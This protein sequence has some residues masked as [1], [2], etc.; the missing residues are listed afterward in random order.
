M[1]EPIEDQ[2]QQ[3][4]HI[5]RSHGVK[6]EVLIISRFEAPQLFDEINLVHIQNTRGDLVPARIESYRAQHKK[7]RLSF[8]VKFEHV[9][10]R[11]KA[12]ELKG[13]PVFVSRDKLNFLLDGG[14]LQST[15][16]TAF[17]VINE[18][19]EPIGSVTAVIENPAHPI[20]EVT[21]KDKETVLVPLV[22]EYISDIDEEQELFKCQNLDRLTNL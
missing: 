20:L 4:G 13:F 7:N 6:G 17:E 21:L 3:I 5:A 1:L 12:E 9:P 2:Y 16:Y 18:K 19:G 8:F 15:D 11:N 10:D 14:Q 22:E